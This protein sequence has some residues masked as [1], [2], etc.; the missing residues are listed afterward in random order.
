MHS[1]QAIYAEEGVGY[2]SDE[3]DWMTSYEDNFPLLGTKKVNPSFRLMAKDSVELTP[4]KKNLV[5]RTIN[6]L[7]SA[8]HTSITHESLPSNNRSKSVASKPL[9]STIVEEE[10]ILSGMESNVTAMV[11][12]PEGE[13]I[14]EIPLSLKTPRHKG[15][16]AG[17]AHSTG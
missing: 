1:I 12:E 8:G 6:S 16:M 9:P 13:E 15:I 5:N 10:E 7:R 11:H 17:V 4:G 3:G 14:E 2:Y